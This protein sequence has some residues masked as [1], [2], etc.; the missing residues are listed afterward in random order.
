MFSLTVLTPLSLFECWNMP[1]PPGKKNNPEAWALA[2]I[3]DGCITLCPSLLTLMHRSLWDGVNLHSL[4]HHNLL[5]LLQSFTEKCFLNTHS[6]IL[7]KSCHILWVDMLLPSILSTT[8]ILIYIFFM[9][10]PHHMF[11]WSPF[12]VFC[13][14]HFFY[15]VDNNVLKCTLLYAAK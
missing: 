8:V 9:M 4:D 1:V 14:P 13:W 11:K 12:L 7:L 3:H 6:A 15:K 2:T 10:Q 5:V